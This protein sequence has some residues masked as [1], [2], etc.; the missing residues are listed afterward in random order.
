MEF[1]N[2]QKKKKNKIEKKGLTWPQPNT[3]S[4]QEP[5][6]PACYRS[7]GKS[8][9]SSR[10]GSSCV[11]GLRPPDSPLD[12]DVAKIRVAVPNVYLKTS[13]LQGSPSPIFL[14]PTFLSE[15]NGNLAL[16]NLSAIDGG[17]IELGCVAQ[18]LRSAPSSPHT[19]GIKPRCSESIKF[20]H[21]LPQMFTGIRE[22]AVI[23]GH[24]RLLRAYHHH[25]GE[26]PH[27]WGHFLSFIVFGLGLEH[28]ATA[29]RRSTYSPATIPLI[30]GSV[31]CLDGSAS[32]SSIKLVCRCIFGNHKMASL[33]L[34]AAQAS[35]RRQDDVA[36][37]VH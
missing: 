18:E 5:V 12:V 35:R 10:R 11:V 7:G 13:P 34:T 26:L 32:S 37:E 25:Q 29:G 31:L 21:P 36:S 2:Q 16:A 3:S 24:L 14:L 8:S 1:S 6:Q 23:S 30:P 19:E 17:C 9:S 15:V 4:A 27:L 20:D 33:L 22:V 28:V